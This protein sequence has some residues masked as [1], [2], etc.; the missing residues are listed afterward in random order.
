MTSS[1]VPSFAG[2]VRLIPNYDRVQPVQ[3]RAIQELRSAIR[4]GLNE[5]SPNE[6]TQPG[7]TGRL[8]FPEN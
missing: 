4:V 5:R 6:D 3:L 1:V 7:R 2:A 8:R